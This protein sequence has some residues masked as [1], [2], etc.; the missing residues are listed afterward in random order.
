MAFYQLP[1][2]EVTVHPTDGAPKHEFS[3]MGD[4]LDAAPSS[5]STARNTSAM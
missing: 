2:A 3:L 1:P 5:P 4:D